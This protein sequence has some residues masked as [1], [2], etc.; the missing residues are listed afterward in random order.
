MAI[1]SINNINIAA[2]SATVPKNI[3][4]NLAYPHV[5]EKEK[6]QFIDTVGI[7]YRR[8][9]SDETTAAD[10]CILSAE[11]VLSELNWNKED[12]SILVFVSQTP[13]YKI[14][15]NASGI[16]HKLG[17]SKSCI[18]FDINLGCS[19]YVYGLSVVGSMLSS[20]QSGK[21]LLLV[22]DCSSSCISS[23][24]KSVAM[25]FS[26]AGSATALEFTKGKSIQFNLQ[27]DGSEHDAIIIPAGGMKM[28][29]SSSSLIVDDIEP[30]ISRNKEQM[31]L[32]GMKIFNFTLRE[33]PKNML[34]L[35]QYTNRG[36]DDI[37]FFYLHQ[38][39]LLM[40]ESVRKKLK[41]DAS[42]VPYSLYK[43]G[44]T[45][46][47]SIPVTIS[48]NNNTIAKTRKCL[49]S[50]FGVGLSWGSCILDL[51]ETIII[52]LQEL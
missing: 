45:S 31:I 33:V 15:F 37:D 25:L 44:N 9:V 11:K 19:G 16:Q 18:S 13:D 49:L 8:V 38:A 32:D 30:G 4:D 43:Y 48:L 51:S 28:P 17:L 12:I 20:M 7:R 5:T 47:A 3:E 2:I 24:D 1:F 40:N 10:L 6:Q 52:P 34:D 46:S 39:N 29:S 41:I 21:A 23:S 27:T 36:I 35:L 14:P 22:G 42:K 50:G 26:D